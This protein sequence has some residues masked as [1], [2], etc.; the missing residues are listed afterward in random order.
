[1]PNATY[2]LKD[3]NLFLCL[4]YRLTPSEGKERK[5]ERKNDADP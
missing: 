4:R 2:T 5:K 3:I 1:M